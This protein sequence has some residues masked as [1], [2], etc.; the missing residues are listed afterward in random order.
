MKNNKLINVILILLLLLNIVVMALLLIDKER[1]KDVYNIEINNYDEFVKTYGD[2]RIAEYYK[3]FIQKLI[4]ETIPSIYN[5]VKDLDEEGLREY[6]DKQSSMLATTA[7]VKSFEDFAELIPKLDMYQNMD[8]KYK[9]IDVI[10]NS[11]N[12]NG[13]YTDSVVRIKYQGNKTLKINV[14]ML[15]YQIINR[16]AGNVDMYK[17]S[18][19]QD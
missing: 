12:K 1:H 15:D 7:G 9:K 5:D 2:S 13:D 14:S 6:Y 10:K 16:T 17:V 4:E 11:C 19:N 8:V 3:K 18:L